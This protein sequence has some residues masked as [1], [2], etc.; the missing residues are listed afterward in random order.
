[1][2]IKT[3][4][5]GCLAA[6]MDFRPAGNTVLSVVNNGSRAETG[7]GHIHKGRGYGAASSRGVDLPQADLI[8]VLASFAIYTAKPITWAVPKIRNTSLQFMLSLLEER[9]EVR[10]DSL[11]D[12][13][14]DPAS[15]RIFFSFRWHISPRLRSWSYARPQP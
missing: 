6:P 12:L 2:K 8:A 7:C 4:A 13:C 15:A 1:V 14:F 11:R 9:G 3:G 5:N 10:L